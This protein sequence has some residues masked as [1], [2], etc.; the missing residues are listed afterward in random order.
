MAA[1]DGRE[2]MRNTWEARLE[3][4]CVLQPNALCL[5]AERVASCAAAGAARR[6]L[7]LRPALQRRQRAL[8]LPPPARVLCAACS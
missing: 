4:W 3:R 8:A 5:S 6:L 2:N 7:L 1:Y